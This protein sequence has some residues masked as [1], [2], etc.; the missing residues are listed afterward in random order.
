MEEEFGDEI[1]RIKKEFARIKER[2]IEEAVEISNK[3]KSDALKEVLP[4]TDN[5]K[6]AK[7]IIMLIYI[8]ISILHKT[9][10]EA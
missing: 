5:Y 10:L 3:A 7:G 1:T 6:R 8:C 4:I 2:S 9:K